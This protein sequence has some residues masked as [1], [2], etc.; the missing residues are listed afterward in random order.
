MP[1]Q[2]IQAP[3]DRPKN[4]TLYHAERNYIGRV[5]TQPP[6]LCEEYHCCDHE[7]KHATH[8]DGAI[9]TS[10]LLHFK[11]DITQPRNCSLRSFN[12]PSH[13]RESIGAVKNQ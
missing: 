10:S 9:D 2:Y 6:A 12:K 7:P 5:P 1:C 13:A 3:H 8:A 4:T 11:V